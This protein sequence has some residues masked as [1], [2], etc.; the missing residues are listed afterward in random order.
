MAGFWLPDPSLFQ[1]RHVVKE[2]RDHFGRRAVFGDGKARPGQRSVAIIAQGGVD[3]C[4][5]GHIEFV[6]KDRPREWG[7]SRPMPHSLNCC[8]SQ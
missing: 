1:K 2:R 4:A 8:I 5:G 7:R 6:M 3:V